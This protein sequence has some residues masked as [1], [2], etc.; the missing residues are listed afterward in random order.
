MIKIIHNKILKTEN[1]NKILFFPFSNE[2]DINKNILKNLTSNKLKEEI[3]YDINI[4]KRPKLPSFY[5]WTNNKQK[6]NLI[7]DYLSHLFTSPSLM[8]GYLFSYLPE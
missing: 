5:L 3:K 8:K 2:K 4:L 7:K 1:L 6:Y